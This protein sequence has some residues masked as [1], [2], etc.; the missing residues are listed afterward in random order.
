MTAAALFLAQAVRADEALWVMAHLEG[1]VRPSLPQSLLT[2][3][4]GAAGGMPI[5]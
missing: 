5:S 2:A 3:D 1:Y 4:E